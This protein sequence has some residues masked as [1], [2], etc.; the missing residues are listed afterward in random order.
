MGNRFGYAV[1]PRD[2]LSARNGSDGLGGT[3]C[4]VKYDLHSGSR[5]VHDLGPAAQ[6]GEPVFVPAHAAAA[7]DEGYLVTFVYDSDTDSSRFVVLD[8][9]DMSS[10]PLATVRL[11]QRVPHGFHGSWFADE[12]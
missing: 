12:G 9:T 6:S 2:P 7:E 5:S 11:P 1:A 4:I 3:T 8:A 10:A